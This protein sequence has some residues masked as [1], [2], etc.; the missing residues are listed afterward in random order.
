MDSWREGGSV[1]CSGLKNN[2]AN[3]ETRDGPGSTAVW[4]NARG[5][6]VTNTL[7]TDLKRLRQQAVAAEPERTAAKPPTVLRDDGERGGKEQAGKENP[8]IQTCRLFRRQNLLISEA[9]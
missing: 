6:K 7:A 8:S 4:G 1:W 9:G 5:D 3:T 2:N